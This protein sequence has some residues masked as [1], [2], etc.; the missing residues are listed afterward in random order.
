MITLGILLFTLYLLLKYK[1]K[2]G[3]SSQLFSF[4][5]MMNLVFI[6]I[7]LWDLIGF[8]GGSGGS[9]YMDYYE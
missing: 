9:P 8:D 3:E 4:L 1:D 2:I 7:I 6:G 5:L